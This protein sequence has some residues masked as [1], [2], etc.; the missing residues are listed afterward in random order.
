MSTRLN[1]TED[2]KTSVLSGLSPS[3]ITDCAS[4]ALS[5]WNYQSSQ[6][7]VY[8]DHLNRHLKEKLSQI[9]TQME[10]ATRDSDT[11]IATLQNK[12][13]SVQVSQQD[14]EKKTHELSDALREKTRKYNQMQELYNK[15]KRRTMYSQVQNAAA[16][17]VN[18]SLRDDIGSRHFSTESP[19]TMATA[20]ALRGSTF[21]QASNRNQDILG[22][23]RTFQQPQN[24]GGGNNANPL[25]S[26]LPRPLPRPVLSR[27]GDAERTSNYGLSETLGQH[28]QPLP[29]PGGRGS[30]V[31]PPRSSRA[32]P[33]VQSQMRSPS[34]RQPLG[35][36]SANPA[37]GSALAGYGMSAG[38]K[39]SRAPASASSP[40]GPKFNSIRST[41][42]FPPR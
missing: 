3:I 16:D 8:Q 9:K 2:Y 32:Q 10:K 12:L 40:H 5:F 15:L 36:L 14:L 13:I 31:E 25:A 42:G 4:R 35:G 33:H 41:P 29:V 19:G 23:S 1:P 17:A 37:G 22:E 26:S 11:E 34:R 20:E 21:A 24:I 28:R 39:A 7:I 27:R 6:E 18:Q 30:F 38:I